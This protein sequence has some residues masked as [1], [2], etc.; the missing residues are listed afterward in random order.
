MVSSFRQLT[1]HR[2]PFSFT[3]RFLIELRVRW[4]QNFDMLC[5]HTS[6]SP[7]VE[8]IQKNDLQGTVQPVKLRSAYRSKLGT[9]FYD[10]LC[11][12]RRQVNLGAVPFELYYITILSTIYF[13]FD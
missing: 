13:S 8:K 1:E 7:S 2:I 12:L 4:M 5:I 9:P 6:T 10:I 3:L 11:I